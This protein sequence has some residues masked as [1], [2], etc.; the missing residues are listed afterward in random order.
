MHY[1][2]SFLWCLSDLSQKESVRQTVILQQQCPQSRPYFWWS[3]LANMDA[4]SGQVSQADVQW[5]FLYNPIP[6]EVK[7][8]TLIQL[9]KAFGDSHSLF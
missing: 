9:S 4:H 3:P 5:F 2:R 7:D 1:K 8:F 6:K